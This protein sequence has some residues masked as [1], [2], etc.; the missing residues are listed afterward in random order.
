MQKY[1]D[2]LHITDMKNYKITFN[3]FDFRRTKVVIP[4]FLYRLDLPE[5]AVEETKHFFQHLKEK[6]R[7]K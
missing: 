2:L 5:E 6:Y 7:L 3:R 1:Q 4:K